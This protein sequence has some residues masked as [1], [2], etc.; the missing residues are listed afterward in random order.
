S[1]DAFTFG[2][3]VAFLSMVVVGGKGTIWGPLVGATVLTVLPDLLSFLQDFK[4]LF[5]GLLLVLAMMFMP[6]GIVD[7]V[8]RLSIRLRSR[9]G[10]DEPTGTGKG[11]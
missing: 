2:E 1:P 10:T 4:M 7:V 11:N 9:R 3:S 5:H 8:G 6:G